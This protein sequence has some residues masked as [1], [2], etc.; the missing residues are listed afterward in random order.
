MSDLIRIFVGTDRSQSLAVKV[1]E[2]SIRRHTSQAFKIH[3]MADLNLPQ[4]RDIRQGQRT[5]FSFARWAIP[6]L[7][8]FF[9]RAIYLDADML[10]FRDIAELWNVPLAGRKIAV[11]EPQ[12]AAGAENVH[13]GK[14]ETSVMIL[15]CGQ[16][17][18]TV[19][20][21][22]AGLDGR[23]TYSQMMRDLCF[24]AEDEIARSIPEEWNAMEHFT[25]ATGLI[26]YT[27]MPTQPWVSPRN[28]LGY[29]WVN[30]VRRMIAEGALSRGEMQAEI[31]LGFFRPSLM[32]ELDEGLDGPADADRIRR[33]ETIDASAGYVPHR[34]VQEFDRRRLDAV[35]AYERGL[36]RERGMVQFLAFIARDALAYGRS[37]AGRAKRRMMNS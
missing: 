14:N 31:D 15:D 3:S 33:F 24:L 22:V 36:A 16:C 4:P 21:L 28:R 11:L 32:V 5:G 9:G 27:V 19:A 17:K 12:R 34:S 13:R 10:V 2:Y 1:L 37:V 18:W 26:H 25:A 20:E 30:E 7:C 23:Y 35:H 6:E 8:D 29:L